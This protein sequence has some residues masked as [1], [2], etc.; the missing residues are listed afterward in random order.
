ML[1]EVGRRFFRKSSGFGVPFSI[2]LDIPMKRDFTW[3]KRYINSQVQIKN[4]RPY[5]LLNDNEIRRLKYNEENRWQFKEKIQEDRLWGDPPT[6][7]NDIQVDM[8]WEDYKQYVTSTTYENDIYSDTN[9]GLYAYSLPE[10]KNNVVLAEQYANRGNQKGLIDYMID[11]YGGIDNA[12]FKDDLLGDVEA[13]VVLSQENLRNSY[14]EDYYDIN[15]YWYKA[16]AT[17]G[18]PWSPRPFP[19]LELGATANTR[20]YVPAFTIGLFSKT[21]PTRTDIIGPIYMYLGAQSDMRYNWCIQD[22]INRDN[23]TTEF[24]KL[25]ETPF[26]HFGATKINGLWKARDLDFVFKYQNHTPFEKYDTYPY[27]SNFGDER[28]SLDSTDGY[29]HYTDKNTWNRYLLDFKIEV[30]FRFRVIRGEKAILSTLKFKILEPNVTKG[31]A[32]NTSITSYNIYGYAYSFRE[33]MAKNPPS[34][35]ASL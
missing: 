4:G 13:Y 14:G 34:L 33:L 11:T 22:P 7:P 15:K 5:F 3:F 1:V 30:E 24:V 32:L 31:W 21:H 8:I 35:Y 23:V 10:F 29:I 12:P 27:A 2:N 9:L 25:G 20:I 28:T 16:P 18:N 19:F 6:S 17:S 26:S